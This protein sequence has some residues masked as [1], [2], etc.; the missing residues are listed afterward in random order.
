MSF[1]KQRAEARAAFV[2]QIRMEG[3]CMIWLGPMSSGNAPQW[4]EP[5]AMGESNARRWLW[6]DEGFAL[7][8]GRRLRNCCGNPC[9][10]LPDHQRITDGKRRKTA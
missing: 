9:C 7:P 3:D 2:A 4:R 10:V 8:E 1:D 6:I 5:G